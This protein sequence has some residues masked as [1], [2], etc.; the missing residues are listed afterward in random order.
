MSVVSQSP[1][2]PR[3]RSARDYQF[4]TR[5]GEG[6]YSTVFLAVDLY[7][8]KTYAV[9]VL[10]KKH[11]VQEDKIKYVNIEKTALHRFGV[12][13]P[14]IVQLYYTF[15]DELSLFFV[16]DFAEYGEL[17][18][19]ISKFGSLLEP[20]AKFYMLQILDAVSFI[21]LKNVI[22]RDLKPEN[23][24]VGYDFNLKIT[25]FGA[26]KL[27]G[28]EDDAQ[29]E[30]INYD[31]VN[32]DVAHSR[33]E[34]K[35]SFVGTAEYVPP[36]LLKYNVCGFETDVWAIGCI[37]FQFFHGLPP[38]KGSTE[39]LTFE[40]II[41]VNYTYR[42]Q[43]PPMAKEIIDSVLVFEPKDRPTILEIQSMPWFAGVPWNNQD[44]I[45]HRKVP[46]FEPY[47][48]TTPPPPPPPAAPQLRT[49]ANRNF[50]KSSS[51]YQLHSQILR[52]DNLV[53]SFANKQ[54]YVPATRLKKGVIQ[55]PQQQPQYKPPAQ[56]FKPMEGGYPVAD[57][58]FVP[59]A[60]PNWRPG[61]AS[62]TK[63]N[64]GN[65]SGPKYGPRQPSPQLASSSSYLAAQQAS[66]SLAPV[67]K[68]LAETKISSAPSSPEL[69]NLRSNTAFASMPQPNQPKSK[70]PAQVPVPSLPP[71]RT[72]PQKT[73]PPKAL[74]LKAPSNHG[75]RPIQTRKPVKITIKEISSFLA[76]EE[77]IIKLDGVLKLM[78]S[79]KLIDRT[80]GNLDDDVIEKL[81]ER[82]HLLLDQRMVPVIAC[83]TNKAK[84]FLIDEELHVMM[85]DLTANKGGDYLMYDYEFESVMIDD[86]ASENAEGEEIYGYLIL[87]LIKEG[88]DLIFLKRYNQAE[89][90]KHRNTIQ[91][92]G[93]TG[94]TTRIGT[95]LG[96]IDSLI[97]AKELVDKDA[98]E[99][100]DIKKT[101][102][103][104]IAP[105]PAAAKKSGVKT[106][107]TK[108]AKPVSRLNTKK[109][110]EDGDSKKTFNK[111]AY[112]A[113]AAVHR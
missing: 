5:I 92:V 47:S 44:Y 19:I 102:E 57:K 76:P 20:V 54:L 22:H 106:K 107:S 17:L 79:N 77:K 9:K 37:L 99:T 63:R 39:Y 112:A 86:E 34:R 81:I 78:L 96:W 97:R 15:Q 14:G 60:A 67:E 16:L 6:L 100:K 56:Q 2:P 66:A 87:E 93:S 29:D 12:R 42:E 69:R 31:S 61:L 55:S 72:P 70:A 49:G 83:V 88:G 27:L 45:W 7:D 109:P 35:G 8:K 21:H 23:I 85:V 52:F 82:H 113:A 18:S 89:I 46:R 101:D 105:K 51:N 48:L 25:D 40:K 65:G 24:L 98:K 84:V 4:G 50:N 108:P 91:V 1:G 103:R 94:D 111:F 28:E 74:P 110:A 80:P 13:H 58:K 33:L 38:F 73:P 64:F 104:T 3:R 36:E 53:P 95:N 68:S 26:A 32:Q 10:S 11:I 71:Q 41:N 30:K 75:E 59:P 43:I 62:P 90:E